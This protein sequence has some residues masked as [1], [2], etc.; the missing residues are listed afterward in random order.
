[1]KNYSFIFIFLT[2]LYTAITCNAQ[3]TY[4]GY[5]LYNTINGYTT[6]LV[7]IDGNIAHS[8]SCNV[9]CAYVVYLMENGHLMRAGKYSGN[10]LNSAAIS[11]MVQEIDW[12]GNVVWQYVYS[13]STYCTHHDIE[14]MPNGNVLL[15]AYEVRSS[16]EALHAGSSSSGEVWS[17]RIVE[18]EP[19]GTN[20]GN[21]VWE[22]HLW[23]HLVQDHDPSKDNYGVVADHPELLNINFTGSK[24]KW[25]DDWIHA[26]GVDYNPDLD[27]VVF[28]SHNLSEIYVIDHSTTTA[29]AA[30]HAGGNSGKGG[31]FLY[32]WG[33]PQAYDAG[34]S[35][36]QVL[37]VTHDA[38]WVH[39]QCSFEGYLMTF[40]NQ[41]CNGSCVN[42]IEP[43]YDGY[44]Y[45]ITPGA[46]Y[47]PATSTW[48][49]DCLSN[50]N[51]QSG[52]HFL[53]NGNL[54]V[55]LNSGY[56]YEVTSDG[57]QV[58]SFNTG[59]NIGKAFRYG[60]CYPG[61]SEISSCNE[62]NLQL[63]FNDISDDDNGNSMLDP[64]ET[65][66]INITA[67]N[68]GG[69]ASSAAT[70]TCTAT[71]ANS[72][73]VTVNT[74]SVNAGIIDAFSS[75]PATHS[76]SVS[77]ATPEGTYIELTFHITDGTYTD[78]L[79]IEP[80][81][82]VDWTTYFTL[83]FESSADWD[84][85]FDPWTVN[86]VDNA[87]SY[88]SGTYDFTH[89]SQAFAFMAFNPAQ[90]TP[91]A[92]GDAA[93]QPHG[94]DR[95]GAAFACPSSANNDWLISPK[96]QLGT[97]SEF[98]FWVKTYK[99]DWGLERFRAC[100]STTDNSP[101][102]FTVISSGTYETA[103]VAAWEQ[104]TYD[105]SAYDNQEVYLA[106]NCVSDDAWIFMVDDISINTTITG[107]TSAT[108][109]REIK[110]YPNP[111]PGMLYIETPDNKAG[112]FDVTVY[113]LPGKAVEN[114][115]RSEYN[116]GIIRLDLSEL[117]NSVYYITVKSDD[118]TI[119]K[120]VTLVR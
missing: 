90:T 11:G 63:S 93:L 52:A 83:D 53:D 66:N 70:I 3:E 5:T 18:V 104:K 28:S 71:G 74:P 25:G 29:E 43:P 102:S 111:C 69:V 10:Q 32:R 17:E 67:A 115:R 54:F 88:P 31:D 89:E 96:V 75:T 19:S 34:G 79:V 100:I 110:I 117:K 82:G 44:N 97:G 41:G 40:N 26:N 49:H 68:I 98:S 118:R 99:D 112:E 120:K 56:L 73:Y 8:W 27:Q 37:D 58:W 60:P 85:T 14:P 81:V 107:I 15:V 77:A 109:E 57:T 48:T 2:I 84:L 64:G 103:P 1:M 87:T 7:D 119:T 39:A 45:S 105:I 95:F 42:V 78:D 6:Y 113:D 33:N 46:A 86:N 38:H 20:G 16:A 62:P 92:S 4:G 35:G 106:I 55:S 94:G 114:I 24:Q 91:S 23:D 13:T 80:V 116:G 22:W 12:D 101:S 65:A 72:G 21:I 51:G 9:G 47:E 30:G 76:I 50:A 59:G 36:D 108:E 61:V